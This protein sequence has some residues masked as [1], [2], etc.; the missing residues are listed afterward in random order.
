MIEVGAEAAVADLLAHVA[1]G[2]GDHARV[3]NAALGFADALVFAVFQHAQ[4][5]RLQLQRQLADFVE[6]QRAVL[7]VLEIARA[8]GR[9]A[10]E[11][12]LCC[13]RTASARPASARSRRS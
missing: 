2:G 13:S 10:G 6:E 7:G 1:V 5:F 8:R 9:G 11:R 3:A 4:Q 12:A